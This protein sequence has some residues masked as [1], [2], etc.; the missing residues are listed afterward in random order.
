MNGD[1]DKTK[2]LIDFIKEALATSEDLNEETKNTLIPL[3][4]EVNR[5]YAKLILEV[6]YELS[7][8]LDYS[9]YFPMPG[10]II[11]KY[12][13]KSSVIKINSHSCPTFALDEYKEDTVFAKVSLNGTRVTL[14]FSSDCLFNGWVEV[15][16][17]IKLSLVDLV[18]AN[19]IRLEMNAYREQEV[20]KDNLSSEAENSNVVNIDFSRGRTKH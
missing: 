20:I 6:V 16:E 15:D 8:K 1:S 17:D 4:N 7:Y 19:T 12:N 11:E 5:A 18:Q 2:Q 10:D 3:R 13:M 9:C 14:E